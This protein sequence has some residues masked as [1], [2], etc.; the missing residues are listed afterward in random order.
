MSPVT[1]SLLRDE[2]QPT[3]Q[4]SGSTTAEHVDQ[5]CSAV[6]PVTPV[7]PQW[8]P[9]WLREWQDGQDRRAAAR[10][11]SP[12]DE[13]LDSDPS[14]SQHPQGWRLPSGEILAPGSVPI[15]P[16][17]ELVELQTIEGRLEWVAV[18]RRSQDPD[19][20]EGV[21]PAPGPDPDGSTA[22]A[23]VAIETPSPSLVRAE[24]AGP[25][26]IDSWI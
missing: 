18:T 8:P 11:A 15:P 24:P 21:P 23:E 6:S 14:P 13:L 1:S 20:R 9:A 12:P 3:H 7:T 22:A 2:K 19:T 17:F 10:P 25:L 5:S 16:E 4:A 26:D